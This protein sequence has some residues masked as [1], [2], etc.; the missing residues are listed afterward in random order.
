MLDR[1]Y[2]RRGSGRERRFSL[3]GI[4]LCENIVRFNSYSSPLFNYYSQVVP[5]DELVP[6]AMKMAEKIA[7]FSRP[8]VVMCKV[9]N[10]HQ[11]N[12]RCLD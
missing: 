2:D 10:L 4:C 12:R 6:T 7:S 1:K 5:D 8:A 9:I 11:F 3:Q